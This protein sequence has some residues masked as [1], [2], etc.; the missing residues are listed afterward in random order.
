MALYLTT[1]ISGQFVAYLATLR[2]LCTH[3]PIRRFASEPTAC[4]CT[5]SDGRQPSKAQRR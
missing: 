1:D 2:A 5:R 4:T 3:A